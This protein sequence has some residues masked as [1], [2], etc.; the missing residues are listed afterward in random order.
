MKRVEIYL[1]HAEALEKNRVRDPHVINGVFD[2][3]SIIIILNKKNIY[4][5]SSINNYL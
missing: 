1:A 2:M 5:D 4:S 3:I